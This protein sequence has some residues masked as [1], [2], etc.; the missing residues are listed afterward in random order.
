[1]SSKVT[2]PITSARWLILAD[3]LTGAA[4]G[5]IAFAKRGLETVVFWG[6]GVHNGVAVLSVDADSRGLPAIDAAARQLKLLA[7][8]WQPGMRLYKKIDS[9]IRGQ[10]AAELAAQL[11]AL[12][13][14]GRAPLAI[15]APAFPATGRVT[16]DG[17]VRV[18]DVPLEQTPL[19]AHNHT[20]ASASLRDVLASAD[21]DAD[22]IPLAIV[23]TGCST[24]LERMRDAEQRGIAAVVCDCAAE[25]DLAIVAEASLRL[26]A[27]VWI[28]SAG[29]AAALALMAAPKMPVSS[30]VAMCSGPVLITVGSL[31]EAS[32]LQ[33]KVLVNSGCVAHLVIEPNT[34][35]S[36]SQAPLWRNACQALSDALASGRDVLLEIGIAEQPDFARGAV[37]VAKLADLVSDVAPKVGAL[38]ATGGETARTLLTRLGIYGIRLIDEVEPGVALGVSKGA[39]SI[40]VVTKAGAFGGANTLRRCLARLKA[41]P[42]PV[43]GK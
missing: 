39:R 8:Y 4:D 22:V 19:W 11:K 26:S 25:A 27:A 40:P 31:A 34:L 13:A 41:C 30:P 12:A 24:V 10:P 1:M 16:I 36:G 33:A 3:D 7:A 28:G 23:R 15:V 32:R 43:S 35:L 17:C 5:A 18:N 9:T 42:A 14:G 37:L 20:Y 38:I 2:T 29:L 21:I 6:E